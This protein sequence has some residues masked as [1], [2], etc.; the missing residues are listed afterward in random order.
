MLTMRCG[1]HHLSGRHHP[2]LGPAAFSRRHPS[3]RLA[4]GEGLQL[5]RH[6][7][8]GPP[9]RGR[10]ALIGAVHGRAHGDAIRS[11]TPR[12]MLDALQ[13]YRDG[14]GRLMLSRRQRLL[15][16]GRAAQE[17]PGAIE[18][19]RGEG[20]IRAWAAEPGEYY[21]AFDGEYGGL[22]RRNGRPPQSW[23]A[24]A[25]RRRARSSAPITAAAP[26]RCGSA[27]RVDLRA[28]CATRRSAISASRARRGRLRARP[29]RS[30]ARARRRT[31]SCWRV[32]GP[33]ARGAVG[34]GAGGAAD[35]PHDMGA[36]SP[37]P[38]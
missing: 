3:H 18:I 10:L 20:G 5:R 28:A 19:R 36:A 4:G 15:L 37:H 6:H 34:A 7:R 13:A 24:S 30:A 1:Y 35:A 38:S 32:G 11:T 29:G 27:R 14:G 25:S 31:P 22:W 33:Q 17:V 21:N 2:R 9:R 26:R 23:S 16:E 8:R 12:A